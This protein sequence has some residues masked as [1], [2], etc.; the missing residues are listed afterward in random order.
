MNLPP[1]CPSGMWVCLKIRQ[2]QINWLIIVWPL[3]GTV[4]ELYWIIYIYDICPIFRDTHVMNLS[5]PWSP[6]HSRP[7]KTNF[8]M[9]TKGRT[10]DRKNIYKN[11]PEKRRKMTLLIQKMNENDDWM[12]NQW[13]WGCISRHTHLN[14]SPPCNVIFSSSAMKRIMLPGWSPGILQIWSI[15]FRFLQEAPP[16]PPFCGRLLAVE[17]SIFLQTSRQTFTLPGAFGPWHV[18][19][20]DRKARSLRGQS[21]IPCKKKRSCCRWYVIWCYM[22]LYNVIQFYMML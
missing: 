3:G 16:T 20:G 8:E 22:M 9:S 2:P 10:C 6:S 21:W 12:V 14:L 7:K 19:G 15:L 4:Y 17:I 5:K 18:I 13:I 11:M 1:V